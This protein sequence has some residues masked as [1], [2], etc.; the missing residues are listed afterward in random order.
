MDQKVLSK[1]EVLNSRAAALLSVFDVSTVQPCLTEKREENLLDISA[2]PHQYLHDPTDATKE[3]VS[4]AASTT[5]A[6]LD[7]LVVFGIGMGWYWKALHPWLYR[8]RHRHVIFIEDN[9]AVLSHFLN[10]P[11]AQQFFDDTQATLVYLD[12]AETKHVHDLVAWNAYK[13]TWHCVASPAYARYRS[14]DFRQLNRSLL[15]HQIDVRSVLE[16]FYTFGEEA[17]RNFGRNLFLWEKSKNAAS[18]FGKF[19]N[20]PAFVVAAGPSLEAALPLLQ[21]LPTGL[22]LSGGSATNAL[23][24]GGVIPHFTATVDP[25]PTQYIRL[26]QAQSLCL[27]ILYRSRALFDGLTLHNGPLLYLRGGDG[28]PLV[29]WFEDELQVDGEV[30]DG[31]NSVSNMLIDIAHAFGCSPII[32]IGYDLSYIQNSR[33]S[34]SV[35]ESLLDGESTRFTGKTTGEIL[36]GKGIAGKEV[37]TE[38]KWV[39]EA[40]WIEQFQS[41]HPDVQVINTSQEGLAIERLTNMSLQSAIEQFCQAPKD[42][43]SFVHLSLQQA[44]SLA[45]TDQKVSDAIHR[46][47]KSLLNSKALIEEILSL[48]KCG[49]SENDGNLVDLQNRLEKEMAYERIFL[50]FSMMHQKRTFLQKQL[51]SCNVD[52]SEVFDRKATEE[53][54]QL[55]LNACTAHHSFLFSEVGWAYLNGHFLPNGQGIVPW[56][57][58]MPK[59]VEPLT[60]G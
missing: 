49:V 59:T 20:I 48:L 36:L 24:Q 8:K 19:Q 40:N 16:E 31:G 50:P 37:I 35:S 25:N 30:L 46:V 27:P 18:L 29:E 32:L 2:S 38:A 58:N 21:N 26:R 42:I 33:Y 4:W 23:L 6:D 1:F 41:N 28:Y 56:P 53:R 57:D 22:V 54:Y 9:L 3:A 39:I 44:P 52:S 60:T 51:T 55:L 5:R 17:L 15:V 12:E 34:K 43:D 7:L 10:S 47:T 14:E 13:Q 45:V 11:L